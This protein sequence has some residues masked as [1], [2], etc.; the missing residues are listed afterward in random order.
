[1]ALRSPMASS[2]NQFNFSQNFPK[3]FFPENISIKPTPNLIFDPKLSH[4]NVEIRL[5]KQNMKFLSPLFL[6][7]IPQGYYVMLC[8]VLKRTFFDEPT[9]S[10][11]QTFLPTKQHNNPTAELYSFRLHKFHEW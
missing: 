3:I 8:F 2:S 11:F 9:E 5:N 4:Q 7:R 10:I 1:M 6:P